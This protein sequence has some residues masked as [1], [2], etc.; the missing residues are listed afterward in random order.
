VREGWGRR[1]C[2]ER[3]REKERKKMVESK[4]SVSLS[5]LLGSSVTSQA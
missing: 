3:E 1:M 4:I 2:R 5:R